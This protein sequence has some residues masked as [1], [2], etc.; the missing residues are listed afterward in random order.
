MV[1]RALLIGIGLGAGV[2]LLLRGFF[3]P[4]APLSE[5]L[6]NFSD[7]NQRSGRT[8]TRA[9]D[10]IERISVNV[11]ELVA[12]EDIDD[13]RADVEVS[14]LDW[15]QHAKD[16]LQSAIGGGA[17]VALVPFMVGW[18]SRQSSSYSYCSR[19]WHLATSCPTS[20]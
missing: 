4:T 13:K 19:E 12:G 15:G 5:Q 6:R 9:T 11:L 1:I 20:M 14:G 8:S 16:K 3:A 18:A 10:H 7:N 17:L 2:W